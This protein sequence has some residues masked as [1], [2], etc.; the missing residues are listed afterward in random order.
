MLV[1]IFHAE[2]PFLKGGYIGVD[3]FFVLSGFLITTILIKEF[4]AKNQVSFKNFYM[5]RVLRLAPA[6]LLLL[7]VYSMSSVMLLTEDQ[8]KTNLIDALIALFYASNW[9]RAFNIHPPDF[10]GH[11]WSLSIEEQFYILW[12][13]TL[14]FLLR[15][16]K[17]RWRVAAVVAAMAVTAW[18]LRIYMT[19][20]GF[21]VDRVYNGLDTRA[22]ALLVGC[23]LGVILA[24]NLIG[25]PERERLLK[26]VRYVTPL[27]AM[28]LL[29][30]AV[31]VEWVNPNMYY[32]LLFV[33]EFLAAMI[34]LDVSIR[35]EGSLRTILSS[36]GIVWIGSI[37]YGL[38]LWHF[39]VY[40]TMSVSGFGSTMERLTL[41]MAITFVFATVS[42]ALIERAFLKQK[43]KY[44]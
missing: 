40:R 10:L 31:S 39:P 9:A 21:S 5:R 32:W 23:V 20:Q 38:Y 44:V 15:R 17:N 24:S 4:D 33:V 35:E 25:S 42:Y 13:V 19:T 3:M 28:G 7:V 34:I 12:P 43:I 2:V 41:G 36:K 16:I 30:V 14:I 6:L 11:T 29:G 22:D 8:A 37:S 27:S 18:F 1:V 26:H